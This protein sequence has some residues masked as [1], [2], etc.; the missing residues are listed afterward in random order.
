MGR[1]SAFNQWIVALDTTARQ[2]SGLSCHD[3]VS[4]SLLIFLP[5]PFQ[6]PG[7]WFWYAGLQ[8][9]PE[10]WSFCWFAT[11]DLMPSP[12]PG[13]LAKLSLAAPGRVIVPRFWGKLLSACPRHLW[14]MI[15]SITNKMGRTLTFFLGSEGQL[16]ELNELKP[17]G[18]TLTLSMS[19]VRWAEKIAHESLSF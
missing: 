11:L 7:L 10:E 5:W 3:L 2:T 1:S 19:A 12:P 9:L 4:P 13:V 16:H 8:T 17:W 15:Q 6:F 14:T 18:L